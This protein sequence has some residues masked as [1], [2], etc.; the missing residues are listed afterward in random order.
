MLQNNFK[1]WS[2]SNTLYTL[3]K[4]Y[5]LNLHPPFYLLL[6]TNTG[7]NMKCS[8]TNTLVKRMNITPN[9]YILR[10]K[11]W[12]DISVEINMMR[13]MSCYYNAS[14]ILH[15]NL[16]CSLSASISSIQTP[17]SHTTFI[18]VEKVCHFVYV[19]DPKDCLHHLLALTIYV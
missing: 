10:N 5:T 19:K 13:I 2:E 16:S 14:P 3:L 7:L 6:N 4:Q 17:F 9:I 18:W 1:L 8:N 11:S 12:E 15:E